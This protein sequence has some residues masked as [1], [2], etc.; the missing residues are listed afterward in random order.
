[1]D[2][3]VEK[4]ITKEIDFLMGL[5]LVIEVILIIYFF[6]RIFFVNFIISHHSANEH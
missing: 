2:D 1:M 6:I 4:G 5:L 3:G